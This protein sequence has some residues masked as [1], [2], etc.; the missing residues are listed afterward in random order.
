MSEEVYKEK[1]EY[2]LVKVTFRDGSESYSSEYRSKGNNY[3]W[4]RIDDPRK[5]YSKRETALESILQH[6]R[7][8]KALWD[9]Q[10]KDVEYQ[11]IKF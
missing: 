6:R 4:C 7:E 1:Y 5:S 8:Q 11:E 9:K 2:R 3:R 10:I